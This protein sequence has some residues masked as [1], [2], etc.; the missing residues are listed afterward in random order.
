MR[1]D[2]EVIEKSVDEISDSAIQQI[3]EEQRAYFRTGKTREVCFRLKQLKLLKEGIREAETDILAALR[4][5]L[6]KSEFESYATEIGIVLEEI[7]YIS[8]KLKSWSKPRRVRTPISHF[9]A[10]S[11]IYPEPYGISLIISPWNYPFQLLISPLI[12][13][14]AA[15]NCSVLKPSEYSCATTK[16]IRNIIES[17]FPDNYIK[18]IEGGAKT[19]RTLTE[20][21]FDYIFFTGSVPVGKLV[22]KS[23]SNNLTP[24]TLELGGKSPAVVDMKANI[25]V[26]ARRIVWGKFLNAGQ[27]CVAPDYLLVHQKVK[28]E[29]LEEIKKVLKEFYGDNPAKSP[30]YPRIINEKHFDRLF[31]L[32]DSGKTVVGGIPDR[33]NRY[34]PP[35]VLTDITWNDPVMQDEIFG[36]ILP[37]MEYADLDSIIAM[38]NEHPRPLALYIF[39]EDSSVQK[40]LV[41]E[42]SYG[43]GC[44]NDTIMHVASPYLPFGG[45]GNSGMGSYHGRKSFELFSHMKSVSKKTTR[46]DLPIVFPPYGKK[47]KLLKKLMK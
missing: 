18:V 13:S 7:K 9:P 41:E 1:E 31:D 42:V 39:S 25:P 30:D 28:T 6:K 32:L 43:G 21:K 20:E 8:R 12:G 33:E 16:V 5:D 29:L 14:I 11:C 47:V 22:M 26:T 38:L 44:I 19:S 45:V 2:L 4:K 23:A 3:L 37:V 10:S 17:K 27:T 35:T 40:R 34:I 15:G 36:P 24:V 46:L